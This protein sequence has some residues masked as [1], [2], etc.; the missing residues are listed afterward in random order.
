MWR[1]CC[2]RVSLCVCRC[3]C[4]P[5]FMQLQPASGFIVEDSVRYNEC[6][7]YTASPYRLWECRVCLCARV[8]SASWCCVGVTN[9]A[10]NTA[11][12]LIQL[13]NETTLSNPLCPSLHP[14]VPLWGEGKPREREE[15]WIGIPGRHHWMIICRYYRCTFIQW[16]MMAFNLLQNYW[17]NLWSKHGDWSNIRSW[18]GLH[19]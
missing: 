3:L 8:R 14:S 11:G 2:R 6:H 10:S 4:V 7:R 5:T 12:W 13:L 1:Q 15:E 17:Y 18:L 19:W 9:S 16:K